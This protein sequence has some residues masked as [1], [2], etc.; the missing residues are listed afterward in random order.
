MPAIEMPVRRVG[1]ERDS[2]NAP[3]FRPNNFDLIRIFAALQVV[4]THVSGHLPFPQNKAL[5]ALSLF[6]GVPI[7]FVTSGYLVSASYERSGGIRRYFKNRFLRIYPGLWGCL[8]ITF[9]VVLSIGYRPARLSDYAWFPLQFIGVIYTPHF[10]SQFGFGSYNGSLWTIPVEL[11]FY[12]LLP[13]AYWAA[14]KMRIGDRGFI[15][16]FALAAAFS[17]IQSTLLPFGSVLDHR[18]EP[19]RVK[20][21]RVCFAPHVYLFFLGV[22]FQRLQCFKW[23]WI[24]G[25]GIAWLACYTL[26][27]Y[28]TPSTPVM[29]VLRTIV[30]GFVTLSMAYTAPRLGDLILRHQD[31]SYGVYIYHGLIVNLVIVSAVHFGVSAFAALIACTITVACLSWRFIER[32]CLKRKDAHWMRTELKLAGARNDA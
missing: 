28:V 18:F 8:S 1:I 22:V 31:I 9:L 7:F 16:L 5:Y 26:A 14:R 15:V 3:R 12:L 27:A 17:L 6:P 32:P 10:L 20:L 2:N 29:N 21:L 30:L 24:G 4:M 13:V 25:K 11:Q 23:R 19:V